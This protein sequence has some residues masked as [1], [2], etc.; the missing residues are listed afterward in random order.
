MA[1]APQTTVGAVHLTVA[2]LERSVE[3]YTLAVGLTEI[4]REGGVARLGAGGEELLV[5]HE[6]PGA[7]PVRGHTGLFHFALLVPT[8]EDL[9][10]WL[11]NAVGGRVP[12]S[13]MSDHLVSEAIYLRDPDW[14]GIEIYRD[15]PREEWPVRDGQ[16][17]MDTIP[18]DTDDLLGSLE[19]TEPGPFEG[20]ADATRM[21]HIHL[22]V[23]DIGDTE[24]FYR[25]VLGF[26]VTV[27]YGTE[28]T[29]LSAGGYH[30]HIGGNTW[31]GRGATPPPPGTAALRHATILLP[32]EA[33]RD[34]VAGRVADSGQEPEPL[35]GGVLVR[36]PSQNALLLRAA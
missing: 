12:L 8:R 1:I 22:H 33:E 29:F 21:G 15:R 11:V 27:R 19:A 31:S 20:M 25:D 18:L 6:V 7:Q 23:A 16:I 13:G 34:A 14:H 4:G 3:Y 35:D 28:A 9:A 10:R 26:D 17:Q 5:L 36:D 30:H 2:D 32:D 24:S